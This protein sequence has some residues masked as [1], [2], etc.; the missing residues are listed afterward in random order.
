VKKEGGKRPVSFADEHHVAM[1]KTGGF[2]NLFLGI[3]RP[4]ISGAFC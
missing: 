1:Q 4:N 2:F 3:N